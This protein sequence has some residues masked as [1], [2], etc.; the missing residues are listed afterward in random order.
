MSTAGKIVNIREDAFKWAE[1]YCKEHQQGSYLGSI[2]GPW[3]NDPKMMVAL[4]D[5]YLAG[6]SREEK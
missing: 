2:N 3:R 1:Q 6:A 5:A 4:Q